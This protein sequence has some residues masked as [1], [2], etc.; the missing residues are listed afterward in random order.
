MENLLATYRDDEEDDDDENE[1]KNGALDHTQASTPQPPKQ[2]P[3]S[4]NHNNHLNDSNERGGEEE[5]EGHPV[6]VEEDDE[7]LEDEDDEEEDIDLSCRTFPPV[8]KSNENGYEDDNEEEEDTIIPCKKQKPLSSFTETDIPSPTIMP[9]ITSIRAPETPKKKKIGTTKKPKK[10]N[11]NTVWTKSISRKGKKKTKPTKPTAAEDTVLTTP[12]PRFPDKNDDT[13][14]M[15]ICLSKVYKAEKVELSEDRLSA[16]SSKGYRM[17]RATRG[18]VEGAWFFEI[19]VLKLGETG[20]T[21]LGWSTDKGDLQA[22]V[23][24]DGNSFGYRDVDGSKVHKALRE[25]YGDDGYIEGDVV[26]CYISLPEGNLYAPKAPQMVW[27]KGHRYICAPD[28]KE[29]PPKVIPV[30]HKNNLS[31]IYEEHHPCMQ[32]VRYLSSRMEYAKVWLSLIYMGGAI[33]RPHPCT[34]SLT[35]PTVL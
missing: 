28:G 14:D 15:K 5:E 6:E 3:S 32:E 12:V 19:K 27:Y 18:V 4:N 1:W 2:K 30:V 16:S 7:E 25:K 33:I 24:Y 9:K 10:K 17:V 26:G 22:P 31:C 23:G 8:P 13:P 29:D 11:T 20:H 21:R 35:S 34:L